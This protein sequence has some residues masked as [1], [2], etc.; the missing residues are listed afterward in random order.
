[1]VLWRIL[2]K[3]EKNYD[4]TIRRKIEKN[5]FLQ[6]VSIKNTC[7]SKCYADFNQYILRYRSFIKS[8][9]NVNGT[10]ELL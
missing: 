7:Y 10:K 3:I 9:G 2:Y 4:Q 6:I 5:Y 1:M 8:N